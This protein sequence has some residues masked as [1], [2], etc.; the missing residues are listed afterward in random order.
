MSNVLSAVAANSAQATSVQQ[1]LNN[2]GDVSVAGATSDEFLFFNSTDGEWQAKSVSGGAGSV[3]SAEH[4]SLVDRVSANSTAQTA[5]SNRV[6]VNS[7][8]HT[9]LVNRVSVLSTILSLQGSTLFTAQTA[10]VTLSGQ[11]TA[12][13]N[14]L[15]NAVSAIVANSAVTTTAL[16]AAITFIVDGGGAAITSGVKGD[17]EIPFACSING[18]T[19]LNDQAG[20]MVIH[21]WKDTFAN[22]PPTSADNIVGTEAPSIAT[23]VKNQDLALSSW[24]TGIAAGDT[25]RFKV[26]SASAVERTTLVLNVT[27]T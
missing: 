6:S 20:D 8:A 5:L 19:L 3:T 14:K 10:I 27:K 25:L 16:A 13:S 11:Q 7:A 9:S 17:L 12:I 1:S 26:E 21:V 23:S 24:T 4:L 15:S 18:W 2:I 22:Y